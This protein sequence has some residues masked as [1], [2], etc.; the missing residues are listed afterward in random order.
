VLF[1]RGMKQY[2]EDVGD[3]LTKIVHA[4]VW[5]PNLEHSAFSDDVYLARFIDM[6]PQG[7]FVR[8]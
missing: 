1:I 5:S 2:Q 8:F 7:F 3:Q 6:K 4:D